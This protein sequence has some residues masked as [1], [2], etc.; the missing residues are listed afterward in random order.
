[1]NYS[2]FISYSSADVAHARWLHRAL[3]TYKLPARSRTEHPALRPDGRRLKPVFRDRDE[4]SA[5]HDLGAAIRRALSECEAL[6]VLCSP[7]AARSKWVNAE[8]EEYQRLGR[9]EHIFCLLVEAQENGSIEGCF[10]PALL[11][12]DGTE[13]LA[14]DLREAK[15]GRTAAK[16]KIVAGILGLD[17]DKLRQREQSRR[18]RQLAIVA[19]ASLSGLVLTS[20]L[21]IAAYVAR[22][23]AIQQR[24]LARVRTA[25]AEQTVAFVKSMF[26]VAD[27]T[28][29]RGSTITAREI[30]DGARSRYRI[31]LRNEPV[32]QSEIALTLSEVYAALGLFRQSD[33]IAGSLPAAGLADPQ[34]ASR[35]RIVRAESLFRRGEFAQAVIGFRAALQAQ[36]AAGEK[37]PAL[38]SRAVTG[39]GQSLSAVDE[40]DKA[41]R[42]LQQALK[43][44]T[45][46]G[47][48][49]RRDV[50]RDLEAIGLNSY[51]AGDLT[52]AAATI[53]RAN[54]I[55]L[56][57]EGDKSPSVSDNLNTLA[58][59]AHAQGRRD[60]A[61]KLYRSRLTIDEQVLGKDHPDVAITLNNIARV[62]V[63]RRAFAEAGPLLERAI[64]ITRRQRGDAYEDLAYMLGNL[65][66]VERA[67]GKVGKAETLLREAVAIGRAQQHPSLAPNLTELAG[68]L[69]DERQFKEAERLLDSAEPVM[70]TDYPDEAWRS[71][72]LRLTRATCLLDDG[73]KD[74]ARPIAA[75]EYPVIAAKWPAG[76]YYRVEADSLRKALGS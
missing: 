62:L 13:P 53:T 48:A 64:V 61:E 28:E 72:W 47:D 73:R 42:V 52:A 3:E 37:D 56:S 1:V 36:Q 20:G 66:M 43:V 5:S 25:T 74:A 18:H 39:L 10:P 27:P 6:I 55:R 46:R 12:E 21:A 33:E 76:T 75:A 16:L 38:V 45:A 70:E 32:V 34:V 8:V 50:A 41:G 22:N 11:G 71:A 31:S 4:L 23:E 54:A 51:Y 7:S 35:S 40:F 24:D 67:S 60:D 14:A 68:V 26:E 57:L 15:D 30:L 19:A 49:G 2:A 63:E 29:A 9:G 59:I 65:A 17:F 44:D 69:C 58:A